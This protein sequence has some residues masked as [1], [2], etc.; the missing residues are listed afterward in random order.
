MAAK[1]TATRVL[2]RE[3]VA[4]SLAFQSNRERRFSV[5]V[6]RTWKTSI[7]ILSEQDF[8]L[9]EQD[10]PIFGPAFDSKSNVIGVLVFSSPPGNIR[11][12]NNPWRRRTSVSNG[13]PD[14]RD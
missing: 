9:S 13:G 11:Q 2:A 1:R 7:F 8:I 5:S 12:A 4:A 3:R 14:H 6:D 10:A